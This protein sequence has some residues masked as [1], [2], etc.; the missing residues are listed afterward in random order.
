MTSTRLG[1]TPSLNVVRSMHS[2]ENFLRASPRPALQGAVLDSG[3]VTKFARGMSSVGQDA[4][5]E[6]GSVGKIFTTTL[7]ALM[8]REGV[9]GLEDPVARFRPRYPFSRDVT[10]GQLASH[11]GGIDPN[12]VGA[13]TMLTRGSTVTREFRPHDLEAFLLAHPLRV[14]RLDT[15]SYSNVGVALLGHLLAD[16]LGMDYGQ[17]ITERVLTPLGMF[18]TRIDWMD[19][20][21]GNLVL[22]HD[23]R[24][25][26]VPPFEW[27]GMEP[28]GVWRSTLDDM[29]V[30]VG[31]QLG[32]GPNDWSSLARDM[33]APRGRVRRDTT[34][35]LG[36]MLSDVD[37]VGCVA[38]H[39]GGT[40]G[41]H[42]VIQWTPKASLGVVLLSNQRPPLWHHL[43]PSRR[44]ESLADRLMLDVMAGGS[45]PSRA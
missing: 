32:V 17:A 22:G 38:W 19:I 13:W 6:I 45:G 9:V 12:P 1:G 37:R 23:S 2:V 26:A 44:L 40:F 21:K 8:V 16:C 33:V 20:P 11:T 14:K 35:G 36:W 5:F 30:F 25:R 42:A 10:L 24:G 15:F 31:A 43:L 28:A 3:R 7:L 18:D 4:V 27:K 34:I 39:S 29:L 41:Q